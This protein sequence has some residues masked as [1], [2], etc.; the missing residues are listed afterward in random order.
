MI[1]D[2]SVVEDPERT[3]DPC[4][5]GSGVRGPWTFGAI[6]T[7]V[8]AQAGNDDPAA[9]VRRWL[10]TWET[11]HYING[12]F[13]PSV[14]TVR[15]IIV[16]TW[17]RVAGGDA[18]DLTKAPF[19]LL[20]I[21]NRM[22]LRHTDDNGQPLDAGEA[23]FVFG[24]TDSLCRK[25]SFTLIFEFKLP[26]ETAAEVVDWARRWHD[27][28]GYPFGPDYNQALE[29]LTNSFVGNLNQVRSNE[30]ALSILDWEQRQFGI[31]YQS[32]D[33]VLAPLTQTPD[34]TLNESPQLIDFINTNADRILAGTHQ[35]PASML[36]GA[37]PTSFGWSGVRLEDPL[38]VRHHFALQTCAGC[39]SRETASDF[40]H[41]FA[42]QYHQATAF[43]D[44]LTGN[45]MPIFD[46]MQQSRTFHVLLDR[47]Q[48][49]QALLERGCFP[50]THP[51][52]VH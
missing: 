33:L 38:L 43:S 32:H 22:D 21:V 2:L 10:G 12:F 23:R 4:A 37:V 52:S 50:S 15:D 25:I 3:L 1:R 31:D 34:I 47:A 28:G 26:A 6:M 19:R 48:D 51:N 44:Y 27:L 18:L 35:V 16:D 14:A 20:A 42:R 13:V 45:N 40:L 5:A 36:G 39:H 8:A 49:L 29:T 7:A 17:P 30:V 41:I 24:A 11:D 9:F 46:F